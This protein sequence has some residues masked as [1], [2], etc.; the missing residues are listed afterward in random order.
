MAACKF[1]TIRWPLSADLSAKHKHIINWPSMLHRYRSLTFAKNRITHA[2][3][4]NRRTRLVWRSS[5]TTSNIILGMRNKIGISLLCRFVNGGKVRIPRHCPAVRLPL[6]GLKPQPTLPNCT[7]LNLAIKR[8]ISPASM[9]VTAIR[10]RLSLVAVTQTLKPIMGLAAFHANGSIPGVHPFWA[11]QT[12]IK[13]DLNIC[14]PRSQKIPFPTPGS[15]R[16]RAWD[17]GERSKRENQLLQLTPTLRFRIRA[18]KTQ[19][20]RQ[21]K[22]PILI[23][24]QKHQSLFFLA[25][26]TG[27]YLR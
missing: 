4:E 9:A 21:S 26:V 17:S 23:K 15:S 7:L 14:G 12:N 16:K 19:K 20:N 1:Q 6:A 8:R 11:A 24:T 2:E 25:R 18:F 3:H 5:G 13:L 22:R 27:F 10:T